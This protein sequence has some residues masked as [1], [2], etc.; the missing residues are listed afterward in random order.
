M[1]I[2]QKAI[3]RGDE[4]C[5]SIAAASVV[6]KVTRDAIM[7]DLDETYPGWG[8]SQHKGYGTRLHSDA[9]RLLG[10]APVHRKCFAPIR[11][12][13][14]GRFDTLDEAE[15]APQEELIVA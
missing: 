10:V 11:A 7:H 13:M 2:P 9:I 15:A 8:F 5:I 4:A 1:R 14:L 3:I 6:A 12:A